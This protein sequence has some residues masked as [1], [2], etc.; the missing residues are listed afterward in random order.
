[1]ST[2]F[3]TVQLSNGVQGDPYTQ[4]FEASG[5]TAP[6][7]WSIVSG[8]LPTGLTLSSGVVSGTP[9][10][11]GTFTVTIQVTDAASQVGASTQTFIIRASNLSTAGTVAVPN[12][13]LSTAD[14]DMAAG[15][16]WVAR[17]NSTTPVLSPNAALSG[18]VSL[19]WSSLQDG[20][21]AVATGFYPVTGGKP[22]VAAGAVLPTTNAGANSILGVDWYDSASNLIRTDTGILNPA[23]VFS[24]QPVVATLTAPAN[25]SKVKLWIEVDAS[26]AGDTNYADLVFLIQT[27]AQ[28]LIDFAN[29]AFSA[30]SNAGTDFMDVSPWLR[31]DLGIT[32]T[33]GRQDAISEMTAGMASFQLQNDT[34]IFT[35]LNTSSIIA[36]AGG[37]VRLQARCQ[38]N[39]TDENG[40]WY[41]RFD[42]PISQI[43]HAFDNT[44]NTDLVTVNVT[45]IISPL[46]RQ[47]SLSSW[48]K[49]QILLDAPALHWTLDD[50]GNPAGVS[51][52]NESSGNNGPFLRMRNSQSTAGTA[53]ITWGDTTG[54]VETLADAATVTKPDGSEYWTAGSNQPS[55]ATRG[56][57]SGVLGPFTSPLASPYFTPQLIKKS[58]QNTFVGNDGFWLEAALPSPVEPNATGSDYSIECWFSMDPAIAANINENYGPFTI[59]TLGDTSTQTSMSVGVEYA[60]SFGSITYPTGM[61]LSGMFIEQQPKWTNANFGSAPNYI[62]ATPSQTPMTADTVQL[63]HHLVVNITGDPLAPTV[64]FYLDGQPFAY[65]NGV[66]LPAHQVYDTIV[67]GA[68]FGGGGTWY[69]KIQLVSVYDYALSQDQ[70]TTHCQLGQYGMWEQ[71]TDD[72]I[73]QIASYA[74]VPAFWNNVQGNSN[75]LTLADYYD[76]S[77]GNAW[78]SMTVFEQAEQGLLFVNAAGAVTFHTRDWRMGYG[79]PDLLLPPDSFDAD[80]SFEDVDTF[81]SNEAAVSTQANTGVAASFVNTASQ[82]QYGVYNPGGGGGG[83]SSL[84][85]G[86]TQLPLFSFSRAYASAG[87]SSRM[88]WPDPNL[89]DMVAWQANSRADPW[90]LPGQLTVDLLTISNSTT[91]LKISDFYKLDIDNV[92]AASGPLPGSLPNAPQSMEWFIEGM[93]ETYMLGQRTIQFFCSPT[94]GQRAWKPGDA[95]YGALGSTTRI[96][97]SAA[98]LN[99]VPADGKDVSHDAGPPYWPPAFTTVLNN[100]ANNGHDF[101]GSLEIRGLTDNLD[102]MLNPPMLVVGCKNHTQTIPSGANSTPQIL[103]DSIYV[104]T[105]GGMGYI[106]GWPNWYCVL[107][108]GF[109]DIDACFNYASSAAADMGQA[110]ICIAR[111]AAADV[112]SAQADPTVAT[113]GYNCPVGA[114]TRLHTNMDAIAAPATRVYLGLGDMVTITAEQDTG[115]GLSTGTSGGGTF[116]SLLFRGLSISDDACEINSTITGGTVV[117][118][119]TTTTVTKTYTNTAT[120]AYY[121]PQATTVKPDSLRNTNGL[122]WQYANPKASTGSNF[123]QVVF[124]GTQIAS[125]LAGATVKAVTL[126]ATN[127]S[128]PGNPGARLILGWGTVVP[129]QSTYDIKTASHTDIVEEWFSTGITKSFSLPS[130]FATAFATGGATFLLVGDGKNRSGDYYSSWAGGAGAWVLT[131]VYQH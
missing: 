91:G 76:I 89:E 85:S 5:G 112:V 14:T 66:S 37:E 28:V 32:Y 16:S 122:V 44:G 69:G 45:D 94:T 23:S 110:I 4:T 12:D 62:I 39:L 109:Y 77:Q 22:Y 59:I 48:T 30:A 64:N 113:K 18:T 49:E 108:P 102:K 106:D 117:G 13:L 118:Q 50:P 41:T 87:L 119:V 27:G 34:G 83:G 130:S 47:D 63:P 17:L 93:T 79:A 99:P 9:S 100:P 11:A 61:V 43:T 116:M 125:D 82:G 72:C 74:G 53:T 95:T 104:D 131:I 21:S 70:I 65:F 114:Q 92:I 20:A 78:S 97:V 57:D 90:L 25:A 71:P 10:A 6:Y 68:A 36:I 58:A 42:G 29:P 123:S 60:K 111:G 75:G 15:N 1:M 80:M 33:R 103:W 40:V 31:Q 126:Q 86:A 105:E 81:Q 2:P 24:W 38:V 88:F 120:Y 128:T 26:F 129:G 84:L 52:A 67:V 96:G 56:L 54:G 51:V 101:V 115:A 73:A 46:Q 55:S 124:N 3:V 19:A 127:A 8:S 107:V 35:K 121:G 7:T 98:D